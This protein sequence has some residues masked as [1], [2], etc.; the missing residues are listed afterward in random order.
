MKIFIFIWIY[1]NI[2]REVAQKWAL[3]QAKPIFWGGAA[4]FRGTFK[5]EGSWAGV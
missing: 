2:A 3:S 4:A 5:G 1:D